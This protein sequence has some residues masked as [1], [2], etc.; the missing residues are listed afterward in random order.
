LAKGE[1]KENKSASCACEK[2]VDELEKRIVKLEKHLRL[3]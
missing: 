1:N 3:V 2:R